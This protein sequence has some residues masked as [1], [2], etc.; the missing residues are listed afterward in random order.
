MKASPGSGR[1]KNDQLTDELTD[2]NSPVLQAVQA[3]KVEQ[4]D[5]RNLIHSELRKLNDSQRLAVSLRY[6]EE[7]T[8]REIAAVLDVS[9]GSVKSLLFR[10]LEKLRNTTTFRR[11][12]HCAQ[13]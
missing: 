1:R 7:F 12:H 5:Q 8:V 6:F 10:S 2:A 13:L 3:D 4:L 9:E 11:R